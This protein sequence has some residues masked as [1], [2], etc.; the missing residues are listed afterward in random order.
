MRWIIRGKC[1]PL[2]MPN[3]KRHRIFGGVYS[4]VERVVG[5][6]ELVYLHRE[7]QIKPVLRG[8]W[9]SI[10]LNVLEEEK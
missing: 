6:Y 7:N 4:C 8:K 5:T 2:E 1:V 10:V 3:I 9:F